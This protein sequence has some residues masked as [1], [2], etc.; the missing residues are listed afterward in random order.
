[1]IGVNVNIWKCWLL[2]NAQLSWGVWK[3]SCISLGNAKCTGNLNI[4]RQEPSDN[5][6]AAVEMHPIKMHSSKKKELKIK[7]SKGND[8]ANY[9]EQQWCHNK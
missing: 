6:K 1:M 8:E 3:L 2:G 5:C 9:M 7:R 4:E